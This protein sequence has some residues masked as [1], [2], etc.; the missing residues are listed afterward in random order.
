MKGHHCCRMPVRLERR[1]SKIKSCYVCLRDPLWHANYTIRCTQNFPQNI[2]A[3]TSTFALPPSYFYP[4]TIHSTST[5]LFPK[6]YIEFEPTSF[7][8]KLSKSL[9]TS[10]MEHPICCLSSFSF[11]QSKLTKHNITKGKPIRHAMLLKSQSL[12]KFKVKSSSRQIAQRRNT[13]NSNLA[14]KK[15]HTEQQQK[16]KRALH[17]TRYRCLH[18]YGFFAVPKYSP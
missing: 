18:Q 1:R 6:P 13:I 2:G 16:L 14:S 9:A 7:Q 4:Y 3:A 11:H 8:P 17:F 12:A 10:T 15:L 5:E